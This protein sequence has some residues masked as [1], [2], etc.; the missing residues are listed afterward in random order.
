MAN[1]SPPDPRKRK[2]TDVA[3]TSD[4]PSSEKKSKNG[5]RSDSTSSDDASRRKASGK[6]RKQR[7]TTRDDAF[8]EF[9][10]VCRD[11]AKVD[12][13]TD[14]TAVLRKMLVNG[15]DGGESFVSYL[16]HNNSG[17]M[18][19]WNVNLTLHS[20]V[21]SEGSTILIMFYNLPI[22][23]TKRKEFLKTF[24]CQLTLF[25]IIPTISLVASFRRR[26]LIIVLM[27]K[28]QGQRSSNSEPYGSVRIRVVLVRLFRLAT[29]TNQ[30]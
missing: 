5:E 4:D 2:A 3:A 19:R 12:A 20:T 28:W 21:S 23:L 6:G 17:R 18:Q 1:R 10:R 7:R 26:N 30:T 29:M 24:P 9:Q 8:Q 11:I 16:F 27:N 15:S 22:T 14:K 25:G 13:Y